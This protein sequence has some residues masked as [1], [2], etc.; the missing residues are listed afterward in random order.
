MNV[1][2]PGAI[3]GLHLFHF[4]RQQLHSRAPA[5]VHVHLGDVAAERLLDLV[6]QTVENDHDQRQDGDGHQQFH[7]R[8]PAAARGA[9]NSLE[10][11]G[12]HGT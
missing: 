6:E 4:A 12:D 9:D 5:F 8:E 3:A 7:D 2:D 11:H 1:G 10:S